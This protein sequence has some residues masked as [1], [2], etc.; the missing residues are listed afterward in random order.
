MTLDKLTYLV[1]GAASSAVREKIRLKLRMLLNKHKNPRLIITDY[2]DQ[3]LLFE[4]ERL[5]C[6][7]SALLYASK[8]YSA[9]QEFWLDFKNLYSNEWVEDN[10]DELR[11]IT[12]DTT[13]KSKKIEY[14]LILASRSAK[15]SF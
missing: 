12:S 3:K 5:A 11:W 8:D 4:L 15:K 9:V 2:G 7:N 1:K 6:K 10:E 13:K 14:K